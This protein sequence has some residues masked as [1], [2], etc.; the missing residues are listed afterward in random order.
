MTAIIAEI[1]NDE[2]QF[3]KNPD[4]LHALSFTS[5]SK[6]ARF[7]CLNLEMAP[8]TSAHRRSHSLLLVQ[9]LLNLRD[10]AS[11]LTLVL[12][13]LDQTAWPLIREF[14][15]RAKVRRRMN[16]QPRARFSQWVAVSADLEG[17]HARTSYRR[18]R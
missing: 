3:W 14:S 2:G 11:P 15:L 4:V 16:M 5:V 9:K 8:S 18:P 10:G 13:S 17:N 1:L 6:L 12:D 7:V